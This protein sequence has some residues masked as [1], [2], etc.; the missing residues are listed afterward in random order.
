MARIDF[1]DK[2]WKEW[3]EAT[4]ALDILRSKC[5]LRPTFQIFYFVFICFIKITFL[6]GWLYLIIY[7][8]FSDNN[9][10]LHKLINEIENQYTKQTPDNAATSYYII[11]LFCLLNKKK[12]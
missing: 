11:R 12:V 5:Q 8:F 6:K 10:K 2:E 7:F 1:Y 3:K 9:M 4:R